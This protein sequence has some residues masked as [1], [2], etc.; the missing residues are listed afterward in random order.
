MHLSLVCSFNAFLTCFIDNVD[1]EVIIE[2]HWRGVTSRAVCDF[3][4]DEVNKYESKEVG[5][6]NEYKS[7]LF[8]FPSS[9]LLN[10]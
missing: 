8:L 1:R 7:L 10:V 3:F 9:V 6:S 4:W 5:R 2:K